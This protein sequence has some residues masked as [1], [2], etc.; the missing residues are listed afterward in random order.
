MQVRPP[1]SVRFSSSRKKYSAR[2][3]AAGSAFCPACR[4]LTDRDAAVCPTCG[5]AG[6]QT[7]SIFPI[8]AP[9]L[10]VIS[11][12][13]KLFSE[14][15]ESLIRR[16]IAGMRRRFPQIHWKVVTASLGE[17]DAGL[18]SFWLLNVSP[19]GHDEE[20]GTRQWTVLLVILAN[21]DVA[22]VPGYAAEVW[23]SGHDWT[24][25]LR[26]FQ[27]NIRRKGYGNAIRDFLKEASYVFFRSWLRARGRVRKSKHKSSTK[28]SQ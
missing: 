13:A 1:M 19:P 18:F 15:E 21:G 5:F 16:S 9:P 28:V 26:T 8:P 10:E 7:M 4:K 20:P 17:E 3:I 6:E 2:G 23:L 24:R 14:S 22:V 27:T 25:L 11:D 12:H